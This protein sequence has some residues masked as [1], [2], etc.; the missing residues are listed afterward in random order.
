MIRD[1][2]KRPRQTLRFG[3][4]VPMEISNPQPQENRV[5]IFLFHNHP[6]LILIT[7]PRYRYLFKSPCVV[8]ARRYGVVAGAEKTRINL[9]TG[10]NTGKFPIILCNAVPKSERRYITH[11]KQ[12]PVAYG[13]SIA[14]LRDPE[15]TLSERRTPG[16]SNEARHG[17][18][19]CMYYPGRMISLFHSDCLL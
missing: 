15:V 14:Y 11:H 7:G 2:E 19:G 6:I 12:V 1:P 3:A 16:S 9:S 5:G 10:K 8:G 17:I 4:A 13:T 18:A